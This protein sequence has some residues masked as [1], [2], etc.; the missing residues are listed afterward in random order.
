M[1]ALVATPVTRRAVGDDA[2]DAGVEQEAHA[3]RFGMLGQ[4]LR[5]HVAVAGLVL[6]QPKAA[7]DLLLDAG[8]RRLDRDAALA[9]QQSR[10]ARRTA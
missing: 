3:E 4:R 8:E 1:P 6:R 5:E 9:A 7:D 2:V 10:R